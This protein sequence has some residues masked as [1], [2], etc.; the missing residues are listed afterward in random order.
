[1]TYRSDTIEKKTFEVNELMMKMLFGP[2]PI[3]DK[4]LQTLIDK[5]P[6][7]YGRF[8]NFIGKRK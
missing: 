5:H 3:T 2:N 7:K 4:E 6:D 8:A 1:M